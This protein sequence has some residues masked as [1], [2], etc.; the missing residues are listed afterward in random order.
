[1]TCT[2]RGRRDKT[3]RT[4]RKKTFD[5]KHRVREE[6]IQPGDRVLIKQQKTTIKPPFDPKPYVVTE[7][8]DTQVTAVRGQKVRVR[9]KAKVKL[10]TERPEHLK[11]TNRDEYR[12]DSQE[13]DE[14]DD[15]F[16]TLPPAMDPIPPPD[17]EEGAIQLEEQEQ[18]EEQGQE[19][20]QR[21]V[22]GAR[23]PIRYTD[24]RQAP[25]HLTKKQTS[26]RERRKRQAMAAKTP[27]VM[28]E[29]RRQVVR[30]RPPGSIRTDSGWRRETWSTEEDQD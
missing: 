10:L 12:W 22:R 9:N 7:V 30:L 26:P 29:Q 1:M 16:I 27:T 20:R 8:K 13:E 4:D 15:W 14:E 25:Q 11:P 24:D 18:E 28:Q 21:P 23:Q 6:K 5:K 17:Q 3:T 2:R 19:V